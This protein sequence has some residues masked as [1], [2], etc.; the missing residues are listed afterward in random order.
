M[1]ST[2]FR[3]GLTVVAAAVVALAPMPSAKAAPGVSL[4]VPAGA[5]EVTEWHEHMLAA[6]ITAGLNP[7]VSTRD[8]A[9]VST[10]VFDAVNGIERRYEPIHVP[11]D[12]PPG[13]SK[14]AAAV[15]AAYAILVARF[16]AQSADLG[17]KRTASLE[18]IA[19]GGNS[20]E[21]GVEWGQEVAEAILD[22]RSTDG[23]ASSPPAY[24]GG[25]GPG[26]W[27]PTPPAGANGLLPQWATMTPWGMS[28]ADQFRPS[29]PPSLDSDAYLA[30]FLEVKAMG[31]VGSA[32]RSAE[33]SDFCRFW[34]T[35][36]P[37][38][39]WNRVALDLIADTDNSLSDNAHLLAT[40]NLAIA[41]AIIGCWD[42][43][44]YYEFWRPVTAIRL[45]DTDGNDDT[46]VDTTWTPLLVTPPFPEHTSGH[47]S[48]SSAAVTVLASAFGEDT[49]FTVKSHTNLSW[50]RE[51]S[52]FSSAID[53]VADAR[54]FAGIH[55]RTAC[56]LGAAAGFEV[57]AYIMENMMGR[58]HGQGD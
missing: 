18:A 51:F 21:L 24:T 13:A 40:M 27:R 55:F 54:V 34:Q 9:L 43:K 48:A 45:A 41:D 53:E 3:R 42:A 15:Q 52:S 36:T 17:A 47:S 11:A 4:A 32:L 33:Q 44:Y 1:S 20:L 23:F 31:S 56:D 25:S 49:S 14:R 22:W 6:L 29:A 30:D 35:S 26:D 50:V 37:T 10:A 57:A 46:P 19:A 28:S 58:L 7:I 38:F 12:A 5:D 2:L 8:A 16:P 39:L